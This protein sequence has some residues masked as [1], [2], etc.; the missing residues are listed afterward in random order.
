MYVD[1]VWDRNL[2]LLQS[3]YPMLPPADKTLLSDTNNVLAIE[4][5]ALM[6][7]EREREREGGRE[8]GRE[9]ERVMCM[10]MTRGRGEK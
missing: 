2:N 10:C 6:V 3:P 4:Y 7:Q 9:G 8:G 5:T 1:R